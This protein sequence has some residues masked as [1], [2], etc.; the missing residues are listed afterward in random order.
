MKIL[1][2]CSDVMN[3]GRQQPRAIALARKLANRG[4]DVVIVAPELHKP[5]RREWPVKAGS[6]E[7][8]D[9]GPPEKLPTVLKGY[10]TIVVDGKPIP[11]GLDQWPAIQKRIDTKWVWLNRPD[12]REHMI[13]LERKRVHYDMEITPPVRAPLMFDWD[14]LLAR[15]EA[16]HALELQTDLRCLLLGEAPSNQIQTP[17]PPDV[18]SVRSWMIEWPALSFLNAFDGAL[19]TGSVMLPE[20]RD[21]GLPFCAIAQNDYQERVIESTCPNAAG[22]S[23]KFIEEMT[24]RTEQR[25]QYDNPAEGLADQILGFKAAE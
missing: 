17:I 5:L 13:D 22:D 24:L 8:V 19:T 9:Y 21:T 1:Y 23:G 6:I 15:D 14:E 4:H 25:L 12:P 7:C 11:I 10:D 3:L 20:V 18:V 2:V 16:R